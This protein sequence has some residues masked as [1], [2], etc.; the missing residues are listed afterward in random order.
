MENL[1]CPSE[2]R[3]LAYAEGMLQP[4]EAD[5]IGLHL[6]SCSSCRSL[7]AAAAG[8]AWPSAAASPDGSASAAAAAELP[9]GQKVGRYVVLDLVGKG[10]MGAV[11]AA[12]DSELDRKVALKLLR[13]DVQAST[14]D[15]EL[16][17]RLLREARTMAQLSH[18]NVVAV[19]DVGTIGSDVFI[20]MD[21][22]HGLTLRAWLDTPRTW[23]EIVRV[24]LEAARGLAA[25][26]EVSIIH[27]DFKADNVLIAEKGRVF[28]ADFGL[29]RG[30]RESGEPTG[31]A[32]SA[33]PRSGASFRAAMTATGAVLGTP[34]YMA[35]EQADGRPID[36]RS[37]LF[38]FCV[39]LYEALYRERPFAGSSISELRDAIRRGVGE[40]TRGS[41]VPLWLR[42]VVLRGLAE[43][44]AE[45]YPSMESLL[46]ALG[47]DPARLR[48]RG[49]W[50]GVLLTAVAGASAL[51]VWALEER[52]RTC[53]NAERKLAGVWDEG[54]K[55][56]VQG[57]FLATG[58]PFAQDVLRATE[59]ALDNYVRRW[60]SMH[61]E[62]CEATRIHG[63]Q[64]EELLDLRVHCLGVRRGELAG[65][66]AVFA[67]ADGRVVEKA[68]EAA[69]RLTPLDGCADVAALR[70]GAPLPADEVARA[71]AKEARSRLDA[72]KALVNAGN[73]REALVEARAALTLAERSK[74]QPIL[75]EALYRMG[76]VQDEAGDYRGAEQSL[77]AAYRRG[78]ASRS[79]EIAARSAIRLLWLVE[80]RRE[81][82]AHAEGWAEDASALLSR[83]GPAP[84]LEALFWNARGRL[85]LKNGHA[86][87]ALLDH[88]R[89][90]ELL[91]AALPDDLLRAEILDALAFAK[92]NLA[93]YDGAVTRFREALAIIEAT[94]G[95][96]HPKRADVLAGLFRPLRLMGRYS[97]ALEAAHRALAIRERA[98]GPTHPETARAMTEVALALGDLARFDEALPMVGRAIALARE[99]KSPQRDVDYMRQVLALLNLWMGRHEEAVTRFRELFAGRERTLGARHPLLLW[100]CF[101]LAGA[102]SGA[103][104]FEEALG[105]VERA[106]AIRR[107]Q[108]A[109]NEHADVQLLMARGEAEVGLG[110]YREALQSYEEALSASRRLFGA[111]HVSVGHALLGAG[112]AL[113]G[114]GRFSDA[115]SVLQQGRGLLAARP[116]LAARARFAL[117]RSVWGATKDRRRALKLASEARANWT[118]FAPAD[119]VFLG[120]IDAWLDLVRGRRR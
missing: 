105:V 48:R 24:F 73:P 59:R 3:I 113:A 4:R 19:Y 9:P 78:L 52:S 43:D 61:T 25:A 87:K 63:D 55:R 84:R 21:F 111:S 28:V 35:P 68:V 92:L 7:V 11:Y 8:S 102:L 39:A 58:R 74:A 65:L 101:G 60:V 26:H 46:A 112:E 108:R 16:K 67:K 45:R 40:P 64:S 72:A 117:A 99:T 2:D 100:T 37:D 31:Q 10:A 23:R 47:R 79:D 34:A 95:K 88:R 27:R 13:A 66:T 116:S 115:V 97:E 76:V 98:L 107:V 15:A 85:E 53:A 114:L 22:V 51:T 90:L 1:D 20:A 77:T 33:R 120:Q 71:R 109:P 91:E 18:P 83:I 49:I 119:R 62:A 17:A 93:Q 70:S 41:N 82:S 96:A 36:A 110:R 44:P 103:G 75:A 118:R 81:K 106:D 32:H 94:H 57:A 42:R 29:A 54:R 38:S 5:S 14:A 80:F 6:D 89:A 86:E 12:Y 30:T 104:R 56:E 69:Q 50:G